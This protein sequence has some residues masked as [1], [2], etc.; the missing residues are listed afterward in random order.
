MRARATSN[1]ALSLSLVLQHLQP[2]RGQRPVLVPLVSHE[3]EHDRADTQQGRGHT[4]EETPL[5]VPAGLP[6]LLAPAELDELSLQWVAV[7]VGP[8]FPERLVPQ[9][10]FITTTPSVPGIHILPELQTLSLPLFE[11]APL[12][13]DTVA[14]G[15]EVRLRGVARGDAHDP[16]ACELLDESLHLLGLGVEFFKGGASRRDG[17]E[18]LALPGEADQPEHDPAHEEAFVVGQR[19]QPAIGLLRG[20]GD[21]PGVELFEEG[22][23]DLRPRGKRRGDLPVG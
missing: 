11:R 9:E 23:V 16:R 13:Y 17:F 7:V 21:R 4:V 15:D 5:L 19:P 20:R 6:D 10:L 18:G 14:H 1:L 2:L 22:I 8:P 3:P 12:L